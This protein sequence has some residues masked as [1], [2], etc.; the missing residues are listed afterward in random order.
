MRSY[1]V[2]RAR[3]ARV[4]C[5]TARIALVS[6]IVNNYNYGRFLRAALDSAL[7]QSPKP[8]VVVVDDGSTDDSREIIASYGSDV[9]PVLKE[10]GGP[11]LGPE[12]RVRGRDRRSGDLPGRR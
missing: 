5:E 7:T 12:C 2:K 8:E 10:N 9:V 3:A 4:S 1:P 6:V 11:D